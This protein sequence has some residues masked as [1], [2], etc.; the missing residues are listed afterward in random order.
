MIRSTPE[1]VSQPRH[2]GVV[3]ESCTSAPADD[4]TES[5]PHTGEGERRLIAAVLEDAIDCFQRH[6]SATRPRL[7]RLFDDA[8]AWILSME[9]QPFSFIYICHVLGFDADWLR[10]FRLAC[11]AERFDAAAPAPPRPG[12]TAG[13]RQPGAPL[14]PAA[15]RSGGE[16][17]AHGTT[18]T[19][20]SVA[21]RTNSPTSAARA[22]T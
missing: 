19:A 18:Q 2:T 17:A 22:G 8:E 6:R 14:P 13:R 3:G 9:Q 21:L 15:R 5:G 11:E 1:S 20:T 16:R 4:R 7:R 12:A 10:A